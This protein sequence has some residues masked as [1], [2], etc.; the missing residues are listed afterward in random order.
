MGTLKL[1]DWIA[2]FCQLHERAKAG[3]LA[4]A[5]KTQYLSARDE[6]AG[7]L[8]TAQRL[9]LKDGETP[10][11]AMR[12]ARAMPVEMELAKGW[13][14][15]LTQ[16]VSVGGLSALVSASPPVG[17]R[18]QFRLKIGR[19]EEPLSGALRVVSVIE[20]K[21]AARLCASFEQLT[22]NHRER[23]EFMLFDNVVAHFKR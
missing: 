8:V 2:G 22:P 20:Q 13:V 12:V 14:S 15:A 11:Q 19:G 10:R 5:E 9:T 23:L 6:L 21:G 16:D 7:A 17:S 3:G 4:P 18:L 1:S